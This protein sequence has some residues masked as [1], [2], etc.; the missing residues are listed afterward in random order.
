[1]HSYGGLLEP[2]RSNL[3]WLKSTFNAEHFIRR[4]ILASVSTHATTQVSVLTDE[5][6]EDMIHHHQ[7]NLVL[8]DLFLPS[9]KHNFLWNKLTAAQT[10]N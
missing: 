10:S 5:L 7:L 4:F 9:H 6:G 1:M 3:I 2:R 8:V